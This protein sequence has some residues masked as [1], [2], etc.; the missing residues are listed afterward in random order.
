[1]VVESRDVLSRPAPPP[2]ETL[3]YGPLADQVVDLRRPAVVSGPPVVVIHGGFWRPEW[4]RTHT[5]PLAAALAG[6]GHPVAQ[7]E[8]RRGAGWPAMASDV[9]AGVTAAA[10]RL[11][12]PILLGHSAGGQLALWHAGTDVAGPAEADAGPIGADTAGPPGP[13]GTGSTGPGAGALGPGAPCLG[14]VAL[15]PVADLAEAHRLDLDDGAVAA[16]FGDHPFAEADPCHRVPVTSPCVVIHGAA[17]TFV[18]VDL[19][20]RFVAR[21]HA[22]GGGS[23]LVE[24]PR[25]G[26]FA[27]IDPEVSTWE[28]ITGALRTIH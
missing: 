18:P 8:Y 17:D 16:L 13:A 9:V 28:Y 24:L 19:S 21:D 2:D 23:S 1:M 7:L 12:T 26:H 4:D 27:L 6:L 15:A 3:R 20:R 14:V 22:A 5:G 25:V 10:S 11:G